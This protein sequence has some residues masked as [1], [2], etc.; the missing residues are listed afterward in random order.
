MKLDVRKINL[1]L[2]QL[3]PQEPRIPFMHA[4][5]SIKDVVLAQE[6]EDEL[7]IMVTV[8]TARTRRTNYAA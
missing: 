6:L 5:S 3:L 7:C 2:T 4:K 1:Q 8:A